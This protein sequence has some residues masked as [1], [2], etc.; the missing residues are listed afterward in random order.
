MSLT[1]QLTQAL[2]GH[3]CFR[4]YLHRFKQADD[5][6]CVYCMDPDDTAEHTVFSCP[7]WLDDHARLTEIL[8]RSLNAGDVEDIL[9]GPLPADLP[10]E[11]VSR[12]RMLM[13]AK[14]NRDELVKMV[15]SIMTTKKEDEREEEAYYRGVLNRRKAGQAPA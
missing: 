11:P 1:F 5:R 8:R 12:R 3:S 6:Y 7:R 13:Q 2:S 4:S 9:C 14:T 15:E 10:E